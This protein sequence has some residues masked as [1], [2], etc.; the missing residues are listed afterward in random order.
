[1]ATNIHLDTSV[2]KLKNRVFF[3]IFATLTPYFISFPD[4]QWAYKITTEDI[5]IKR[6]LN[7]WK[8]KLFFFLRFF[9]PLI[10]ILTRKFRSFW[11]NNELRIH[12]S[13]DR[14]RSSLS[15]QK[16][17]NFRVGLEIKGKK[18]RRKKKNSPKLIEIW[19]VWKCYFT[20]QVK[21]FGH[22]LECHCSL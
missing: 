14:S 9:V 21:I 12:C 20:A 2:I 13:L 10:S 18:N 8:K 15:D 5:N 3:C 1:M 6:S 4:A 17:R 22:S 16:E 19:V 11:S 7:R